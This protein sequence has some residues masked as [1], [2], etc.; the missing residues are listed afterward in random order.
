[1]NFIRKQ[2]A[3][4]YSVTV[5]FLLNQIGHAW[6]SALHESGLNTTLIQCCIRTIGFS[7]NCMVA[8]YI[9]LYSY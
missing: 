1:M 2:V 8:N 7:G 9:T 6:L 4:Y 3:S 5:P